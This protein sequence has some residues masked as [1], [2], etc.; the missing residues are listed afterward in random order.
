MS[1]NDLNELRI[2]DCLVPTCDI[3]VIKLVKSLLCRGLLMGSCTWTTATLSTTSTEQ[4]SVCRFNLLSGRLLCR[5][6]TLPPPEHQRDTVLC[7][8]GSWA[9]NLWIIFRSESFSKKMWFWGS[10]VT[11]TWHLIRMS[12]TSG[13]NFTTSGTN[14]YLEIR[15]IRICRLK[16]TTTSQDKQMCTPMTK[17]TQ[18]L[19]Y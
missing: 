10:E 5:W 9:L 11:A 7:S 19:F 3:C 16:V 15:L 14:L 4:P 13:G 17:Y 8:P 2:Y 1:K 12:L 6:V 18:Y